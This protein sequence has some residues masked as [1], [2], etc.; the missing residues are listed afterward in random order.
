MAIDKKNEETILSAEF[1]DEIKRIR[2]EKG[3][4]IS[5]VAEKTNIK[6]TYIKAIEDGDLNKLPGGIYN[7]A[8]IRSI[9]EFL[10]VNTRP[11]E[12]K[13][14]SEEF[15]E[16]EQINVSIG[17]DPSSL[18]PSK[19]LVLTALLGIIFVYVVFFVGEKDNETNFMSSLEKT[20]D[21]LKKIGYTISILPKNAGEIKYMFEDGIKV[22]VLLEKNQILRLKQRRV[23]L[24]VESM[25][26]FE[27]YLNDIP[28]PDIS[29]I[30][31]TDKGY[32]LSVE[33]LFKLIEEEK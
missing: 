1:L 10:G 14:L 3:I 4:S 22:N 28:V 21:S 12:K 29:N 15:I 31:K 5:E 25:S 13:V 2:E 23:I 20:S 7:R 9:S 19:T 27:I 17:R 32:D 8:Y 16:G 24:D 30:E 6:T 18:T 33:H 11:F 26:G